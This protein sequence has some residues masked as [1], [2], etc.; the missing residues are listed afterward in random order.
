[1]FYVEH[2]VLLILICF[3]CST[4]NIVFKTIYKSIFDNV[5]L[6]KPKYFMFYVE[7]VPLKQDCSLHIYRRYVQFTRNF[8]RVKH[9]FHS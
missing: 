5:P 2:C 7:H 6:V 3:Q 1:M 9:L 4:W 8:V